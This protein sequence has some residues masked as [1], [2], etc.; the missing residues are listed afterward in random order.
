MKKNLKNLLVGI[1]IL[2]IFT[3]IT[4][5]SCEGI[6]RI[7]NVSHNL[8]FLLVDDPG[9]KVGSY[10]YDKDLGWKHTP[11]FS[12]TFSWGHRDTR[13][14]INKDGFRDNEYDKNKKAN[15]KRIAIIGC[16]RT[17]GYGVNSEDTYA[18]FLE[19]KLNEQGKQIY[20]V[21]N[22]GVNGYGVDQMFLNY[23]KNVRAFNP[24]I[25]I[26]QLYG[27]N[28]YRTAFTKMWG[29]QKPAFIVSND[30]LKLINSPVPN[31][32]FRPFERWIVEHSILYKFVKDKLLKIEEINKLKFKEKISTNY[33]L[34]N[35]NKKILTTF[36]AEVKND[37]AKFFVFLWGKPNWIENVLSET[38]INYFNINDY[39]DIN[40]WEKKG[41]LDNPPPTGHWSIIGNQFVA[42]GIYN[43]LVKSGEI[44]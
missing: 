5:L 21:I 10:R 33:Q 22:F 28:I 16:S 27:P 35:L 36:A 32:K 11:G 40:Y 1:I 4:L 19:K 44:K 3:L 39:S 30:K 34:I 20:E 24:D 41:E 8:K 26:M 9:R 37:G 12:A 6:F 42:E 13:E 14:I 15:V 25:V 31:N 23:L 38:A 29:T 43:Y 7:L 2:F 17:Y 18:K